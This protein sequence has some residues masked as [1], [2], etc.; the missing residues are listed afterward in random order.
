M[1]VIGVIDLKGG[2]AVHARGGRRDRYAPVQQAAAVAIDGD[3]VRLARLYLETFGIHDIYIADLDAIA[4]G[5]AHGDVIRD[6]SRLGARVYVDAGVTTREDA[7]R[8]SRTGAHTIVVGLETLSSFE[9]LTDIRLHAGDVV[10]SLDLR[11]G[12]PLGSVGIT[13]SPEDVARR[14]GDIAIIVLDI[15]RVGSSSGPDVEMLRRIRNAVP[16]TS[17][18]A[19]GGIRSLDDLRLL[20]SIGIDGALIAT[21][22]HDGRITPADVATA[23]AL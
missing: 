20:A 10:F 14:A 2:C 1:R 8:L 4:S 16:G 19:A 22:L 9:D 5:T 21:A 11:N 12:V 15:A 13:I 23:R 17:L 7:Q 18:F 6:V 3:A